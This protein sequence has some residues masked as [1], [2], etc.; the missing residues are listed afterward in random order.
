ME[1]KSKKSNSTPVMAI[2]I[3]AVVIIVIIGSIIA[4]VLI[5]KIKDKNSNTTEASTE[6]TTEVSQNYEVQ[7]IIP[8]KLTAEEQQIVDEAKIRHRYA[9]ILAGLELAGVWPDDTSLDVSNYIADSAFAISDIDGDGREELIIR[10]GNLDNMPIEEIVYGY[11]PETDQIVKEIDEYPGANYYSNGSV[12]A[13][14]SHNH[15]LGMNFWPYIVYNYDKASDTY[16]YMYSVATWEKDTAETD[17]NG[18]PFPVEQDVD[19]DGV[20][21]IVKDANGNELSDIRDVDQYNTWHDSIFGGANISTQSWIGISKDN[22]ASYTE[23]YLRLLREYAVESSGL[24][25]TDVGLVYLE[26]YGS[27]DSV[28]ATI[29]KDLDIRIEE[30]ESELFATGYSDDD[31]VMDFEYADG[32]SITISDKYV[33]G[34]TLLGIAPGTSEEDALKIIKCYGFYEDGDGLYITGD[35]WDNYAITFEAENGKIKSILIGT[36]SKYVN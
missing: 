8:S 24:S 20:I 3:V 26:N 21:Y 14:M 5:L 1:N 33:E 4:G 9:D 27:L 17:E 29:N 30:D 19:E 10:I 28:K 36:Y 31:K 23:N 15:S 16:T 22:Y 34:L 35:G 18:N 7:L 25:S 11:N 32:G 6:E 2:A 12:M 13:T